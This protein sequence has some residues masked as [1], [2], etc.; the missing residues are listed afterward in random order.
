MYI[1]CTSVPYR[2][3]DSI[4]T[5]GGGGRELSG[6]ARGLNRHSTLSEGWE[7]VRVE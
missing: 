3:A 7:G 4:I 1:M 5:G 2:H 6:T